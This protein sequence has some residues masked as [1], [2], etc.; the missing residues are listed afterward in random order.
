MVLPLTR[1]QRGIPFHV[2]VPP[3]EG[4]LRSTS[5]VLCDQIRTVSKERLGARRGEIAEVTMHRIAE[6]L[7]VL[8][9]L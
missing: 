7:R 2:E 3:P 8:L 1:T 5:Y 6:R 4:G 9:D